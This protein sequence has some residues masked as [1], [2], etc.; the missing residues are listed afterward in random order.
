MKKNL[1]FTMSVVLLMAGMVTTACSSD[2]DDVITT[3]TPDSSDTSA[4]NETTRQL[5]KQTDFIKT[6]TE[7]GYLHYKEGSWF[8]CVPLICPPGEIM[9][10]ASGTLYCLYDL[11]EEYQKEGLW[12][13]ATMD[14]YTYRHFNEDVMLVCY[15][16]FTYYDAVIK[17]IE[18]YSRDDGKIIPVS[19]DNSNFDALY[20]FF[21]KELPLTSWGENNSAF[22]LDNSETCYFINS[23]DD[24]KAIYT[25][26]EQMPSIDFESYTLIIGQKLSN[27]VYQN[28]DKQ[29]FYERDGK[30]YLDLY[31][32]G[33]IVLPMFVY[34]NYW[35]LYPKMSKRDINVNIIEIAF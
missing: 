31:F 27:N 11:P 22:L 19:G 1:L 5:P 16:G 23:Y 17:Q 18:P 4:T 32:S 21:N 28:L 20:D 30:T 25:G 24:L 8:I 15:G 3:K 2:D 29:S 33:D 12:V 6:V 26:K 34:Y 35:G 7:T 14:A 13:K 9:I 10:D